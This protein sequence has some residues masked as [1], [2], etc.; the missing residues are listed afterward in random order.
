M[1]TVSVAEAKEQLP[2]LLAAAN[3]G[4]TIIVTR[5]GRP[6]AEITAPT[7]S[8]EA[9]RSSLMADLDW[10]E[11]ERIIPAEP[12]DSVALIR[13]MRENADR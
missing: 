9:A 4:E 12:I 5:H 3:A 6:V 13:A 7:A 10:L 8:I 1:R 11:A 2:R